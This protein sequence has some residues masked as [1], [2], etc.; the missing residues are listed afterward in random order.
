MPKRKK[1]KEQQGQDAL[2]KKTAGSGQKRGGRKLLSLGTVTADLTDE[3]VKTL[4]DEMA[5]LIMEGIEE[6]EQGQPALPRQT[7]RLTK[8]KGRRLRGTEGRSP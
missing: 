4:A 2:P 6:P 7:D 5:E 8:G 3:E 1:A